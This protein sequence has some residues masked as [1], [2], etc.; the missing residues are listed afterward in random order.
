MEYNP[1]DL[2]PMLTKEERP[3]AL[4]SLTIGIREGD[5]LADPS[6]TKRVLHGPGVA[7]I[8]R[9]VD[10]GIDVTWYD[11]IP[12]PGSQIAI[13]F[14]CI[15]PRMDNNNG[16]YPPRPPDGWWITAG[17]NIHNMKEVK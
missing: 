9:F 15:C 17:C 7:H 8:A 13:S 16:K 3:L 14:G 5:S 12:N 4:K 10:G 2:V 11:E 1:A 6:S